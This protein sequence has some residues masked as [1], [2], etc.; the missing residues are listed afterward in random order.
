MRRLGV[1][2]LVTVRVE[3]LTVAVSVTNKGN[4]RDWFQADVLRA[5]IDRLWYHS[6]RILI[7]FPSQSS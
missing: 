1:P 5:A 4:L 7:A 3:L 2:R 6:Y